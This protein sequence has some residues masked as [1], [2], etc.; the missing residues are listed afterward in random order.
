MLNLTDDQKKAIDLLADALALINNV[1]DNDPKGIR[2]INDCVTEALDALVRDC[3]YDEKIFDTANTNHEW[4]YGSFSE[5]LEKTYIEQLGEQA[6]DKGSE[7]GEIAYRHRSICDLNSP[8]QHD[9]DQLNESLDLVELPRSVRKMF[10][11]GFRAAVDNCF[12]NDVE[13]RKNRQAFNC[14]CSAGWGENLTM[15]DSCRERY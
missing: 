12:F 2:P 13:N 3:G 7:L 5:E 15:C 11:S 8:N 6:F 14:R 10:E 4:G 1:I 9:L